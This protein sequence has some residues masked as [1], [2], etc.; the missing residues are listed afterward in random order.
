MLKD[1]LSSEHYSWGENCH[2]WKL[3]DDENLRVIEEEMPPHTSEKMHLHRKAQQ[4]FYV[5]S[6]RG[7]FTIDDKEFEIQPFQS[8]RIQ[9]GQRHKIANA[10][11][12]PLRFLVISQPA[13]S[14]DREEIE[15]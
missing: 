6:G 5:L 7:S 8:C 11:S 2:G 13:T 4:V 14:N 1:R 9:P 3:C 15:K 12:S 10:S